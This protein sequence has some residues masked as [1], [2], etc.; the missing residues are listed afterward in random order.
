LIRER[1]AN[2]PRIIRFIFPVLEEDNRPQSDE[3]RLGFLLIWNERQE[4]EPD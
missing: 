2:Q 1:V 3:H 4:C